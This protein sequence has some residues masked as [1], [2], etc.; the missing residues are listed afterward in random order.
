[1]LTES[2]FTPIQPYEYLQDEIEKLKKRIVELEDVIAQM[3]A[4]INI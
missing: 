1:M 3:R 4:L 2:S